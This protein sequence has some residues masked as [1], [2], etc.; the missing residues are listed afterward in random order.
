MNDGRIVA[1]PAMGPDYVES[2]YAAVEQSGGTV[3]DG[4]WSGRWLKQNLGRGDAVHIH[5]PSFLYK[6]DARGW[7]AL[8]SFAR[9][10]LLLVIIRLRRARIF[11]TAHNLMPHVRSSPPFLD[12]LGR[13]TIIAVSTAIFVHGPE[14]LNVLCSEFPRCRRKAVLIPHGH[15]IGR[16]GPRL[17]RETAR[18]MLGI[19]AEGCMYLLF[20]QC[21]PYKNLDGMIR[22]FFNAKDAE[23]TLVIAGSFSDER[24]EA[25]IMEMASKDRNIIV[26]PGFVADEDVGVYLSAANVMCMPY[27]E[28]LTSGTAMLAMSYGLPTISVDRGYLR[29]VVT[30]ENG[31]LIRP[32][33]DSEL[34]AAIREARKRPWDSKRI[35]ELAG[36]HTFE[37]AA[38]T[39]LETIGGR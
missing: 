29:D 34:E 13:R 22:A 16:Y 19:P 4:V 39:M 33:D 25:R 20:G 18:K 10:L 27:R 23:D 5:W 6:P 30:E 2:L 28:I 11:W 31:L 9:F 35:V 8:H 12:V 1:F 21:K 26:R 36:A 17:E 37:N 32:G 7:S 14:A 24:F 38:L 3:V 15:W